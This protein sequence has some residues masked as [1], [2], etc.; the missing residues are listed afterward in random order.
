MKKIALFF[1]IFPVVSMIAFA[2]C[3]G[4]PGQAA[5]ETAVLASKEPV[6]SAE[7]PS[8][9]GN[10]EKMYK[11]GIIQYVGHPALDAAREGFVRSLADNGFVDGQNITIDVQNAQA[12]QSNLKTISRLFVNNKKDL[13]LAIAA[14]AAQ[15]V[16]SETTEIPVLCTAISDYVAANLVESNEAPGRNLSG[17]TDMNPVK[18]QIILLKKLVPDAKNIGFVYSAEDENTVLQVKMAKDACEILDFEVTEASLS[19]DSNAQQVTQSLAEKVDAVYVPND[20]VI[21][22]A[23]ISAVTTSARIP[24]ICGEENMVLSGGL[25]TVGI[26]YSKLGYQTGEMA[27]RILQDKAGIKDMP[28]ESPKDFTYLINGNFADAIGLEIPDYLTRYIVYPE[29]RNAPA[30]S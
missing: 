6:L 10:G 3:S 11:I 30:A 29:G 1:V 2:G 4:T 25:A 5:S 12:D 8:D 9:S 19:S 26:D 20:N 27:V 14:P 17:T 28:I 16:A 23:V 18:Q 21:D 13:I 15:A 7:A 22:M 24:V